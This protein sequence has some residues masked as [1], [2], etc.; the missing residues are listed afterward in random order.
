MDGW[1]KTGDI[2]CL[3]EAGFLF[4]LE[5]RSDLIISGGE[6]IYPTEIEQV[7]SNYEPV[8]EVAVVG[9]ADLK[10]GSVPV[11]YIVASE[12]FNEADLRTICQTNLASYKIPK[13]FVLVESL[14]KTAS[15]KIKRNQLKEN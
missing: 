11:A 3:D 14:P 5:R 7:I 12:G 10:W 13:Q 9:K 4:V 6:N 15:G 1:F 8:Q 2:G